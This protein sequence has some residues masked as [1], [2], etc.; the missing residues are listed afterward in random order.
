MVC[1]KI[2]WTM[3]VAFMFLKTT[4]EARVRK[5]RVRS[6]TQQTAAEGDIQNQQ[7]DN[8]YNEYTEY[9]DYNYEEYD[10]RKS[11]ELS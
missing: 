11:T 7:P 1:A 3:L 4:A 6:E 8:D 9:E 2:I 5:V 10:D